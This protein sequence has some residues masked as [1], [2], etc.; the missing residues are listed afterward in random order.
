MLDRQTFIAGTS[1][2]ISCSGDGRPSPHISW[3]KKGGKSL[4]PKR[5]TQVSN[6]SLR[7]SYVKPEDDGTF[8]CTMKQTK[9]P[10]RVTSKD[11]SIRVRVIS[12]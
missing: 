1:G 4:D 2:T 5:F 9:G 11:K 10:K 8:T 3:S 6:G 12:E 7:I